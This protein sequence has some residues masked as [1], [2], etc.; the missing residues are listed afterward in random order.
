[1]EGHPLEAI[2]SAAHAFRLNPHPPSWYYWLQG[3]AEYSARQYESA[4]ATLRNEATYGTA[5]RSILAAALAQLGRIDE[6]RTEGRLFMSDYP[7]FRIETF[8]DT[9]PFRLASDRAHFAEGYRKAGLP[10]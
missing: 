8:L 10:E 7:D 1:M 6:G 5:A 2:A 4:V 3:E 9:Q